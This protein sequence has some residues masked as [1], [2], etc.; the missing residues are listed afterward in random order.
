MYNNEKYLISRISYSYEEKL[1]CVETVNIILN[2]L[3]KY[4]NNLS[5]M[6]KYQR[7]MMNYYIS[8]AD[9]NDYEKEIAYCQNQIL[10]VIKI[11]IY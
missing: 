1:E 9:I 3:S 4:K 7:Y 8:K 11:M 2:F 10:K 5:N 6:F